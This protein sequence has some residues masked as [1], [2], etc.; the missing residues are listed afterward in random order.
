VLFSSDQGLPRTIAVWLL[1]LVAASCG[2][3][4][5]E[6]VRLGQSLSALQWTEIK[7]LIASDA[8]VGD[9]FGRA[10]AIGGEHAIVGA[11]SNGSNAGAAYVFGRDAGGAQNWGEVKKLTASDAEV[12]DY[13]GA[14]VAISGD[15]AVVGARQEDSGGSNAGAAY[16]FW[17]YQG[18]TDNWG[19]VRKLLASDA[20]ALD[21]F[22][23]SVAISGDIV[24]VGADSEDSF[25]GAS[26]S[27][28][29][30]SRNQG[31]SDNWG[32]LKKINA[33]DAQAGDH[34]GIS[35]ALSGD[36]AVVGAHFEDSG[37][38]SA[39]AAYVFS[40]NQGGADNWGEVKKLVASDA[41]ADDFFG[42][43][44]AVD[45]DTAVV[46]AY[47][48]D[49]SASDGGAAYVYARNQGGADNWGQVKKLMASDAE[50]SDRFGVSV[51]VSADAALVGAYQEDAGG[52]EAGAAYVFE[53]NL[54]GADNW[55]EVIKLLASD[56]QA[57]DL[58]GFSVGVSGVW[59]MVGAYGEDS[60]GSAAGAAYVSGLKGTNG[61]SCNG[62]LDCI[63]GYCVDGVCCD[64]ACGG[65]DVNDC[66][67]CSMAAGATTD[68]VCG[69]RGDG[70]ACDDGLYCNGTETCTSGTCGS[71]SGDPCDGPDGDGDCAESCDEGGDSCT[72]NDTDASA[73]DDGLYC[74]GTETCTAGV[75]GGSTGDPC[76][77][78]IA[79]G[80]ADCAE[81]CDESGDSCSANEPDGTSCDDGE[82]CNGSDECLN[83]SCDVHADSCEGGGGAG[84]TSAGGS[85]GV[86][87]MIEGGAGG[88]SAGGSGA[89]ATTP[90]AS[91]SNE[92]EG[93]CGCHTPG[94]KRAPSGLDVLAL[95]AALALFRRR[96]S[97]NVIPAKA[98]I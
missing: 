61:E 41:Q 16:V 13:F 14:S 50:A 92:S 73:C 58:F 83:G 68:G 67:A 69:S 33:S 85:G 5:G 88:T 42:I 46:G 94:R 90:T 48:E 97:A 62:A 84:G 19:E 47:R 78:T 71:S 12:D 98:G 2:S 86:G 95:L 35:A 4:S 3:D 38:P 21:F 25:G 72:A 45:I 20:Q 44:V 37:G 82:A 93:G 64:N 36:V 22:G 23:I 74:N 15:Y 30:F 27:V 8:A 63:S 80:D 75:C 32:Q 24:I 39:G 65:G 79:D 81:A 52:A 17:R 26:G 60:G 1:V 29:V 54:G 76:A 55:G 66:I 51:S 7:K 11:E 56:A 43:T 91:A 40:R 53:R 18:G 31:G 6:R 89:A 9:F 49:S 10:V 34:F 28:Y 87:G 57:D 59:A 77:A 96:R 70:S